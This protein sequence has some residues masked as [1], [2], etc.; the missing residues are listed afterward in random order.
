M[1]D[2]MERLLR[3]RTG[4]PPAYWNKRVKAQGPLSEA[5]LRAWLEKEGVTGYAAQLLVWESHLGYPDFLT[6]RAEELIDE[7]Y[8]GRPALR[9]V[10]DRVLDAALACGD[11]TVQARKTYV[12]LVTG[13]RTFAR[14][15]AKKDHVA[16]GL[17]LERAPRG[18][19]R[20]S[21]IH[22]SM[23]VQL[24]LARVEDVDAEARRILQSA[25]DAS[26]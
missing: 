16:V 5:K 18:R 10:L 26:A 13:R 21:R 8:E 1:R 11:V 3:E 14:V 20:P 24:E 9:R 19:L 12:S 4:K 22:E 7:Q 2:M 15:Q 23:P 25:Y 6:K 17:R